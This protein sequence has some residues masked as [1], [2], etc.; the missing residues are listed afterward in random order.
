MNGLSARFGGG[1][2]GVPKFIKLLCSKQ[3]LLPYLFLF[4]VSSFS[5][6]PTKPLSPRVK[7]CNIHSK[8]LCE[9]PFFL[10]PTSFKVRW[11]LKARLGGLCV[12]RPLRRDRWQLCDGGVLL[13]FCVV[14]VR[15]VPPIC[16]LFFFL[17]C[18]FFSVLFDIS[19]AL[20]SSSLRVLRPFEKGFFFSAL[21]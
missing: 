16:T 13:C 7:E 15:W 17:R 21:R 3:D 1:G 8:A 6:W 11:V 12:V 9:D 19:P 2:G 18:F 20:P 14:I 4:Y 5:C 10:S